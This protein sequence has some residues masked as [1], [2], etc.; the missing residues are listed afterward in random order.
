[1]KTWTKEDFEQVVEQIKEKAAV[2][3]AFRALCV[4]DIHAAIKQVSGQEPPADMKIQVIDGAGYHLS[5]ALPP[6]AKDDG[7]EIEEA[8]LDSVVGGMWPGQDGRFMKN[9]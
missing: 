2:D 8:D 3:E 9:D 5:V 6:L 4:K 7:G 1:M